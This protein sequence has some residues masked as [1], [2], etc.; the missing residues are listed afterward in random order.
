MKIS[1][2]TLILVVIGLALAAIATP[3]LA[4]PPPLYKLE[5]SSFS[6]EFFI[7][8][9]GCTVTTAELSTQHFV[10]GRPMAS[11]NVGT[12]T[13]SSP[14]PI[15]A[16]VSVGG[17]D[18]VIRNGAEVGFAV[19]DVRNPGNGTVVATYAILPPDQATAFFGS[20]QAGANAWLKEHGP[21]LTY[22]GYLYVFKGES[23]TDYVVVPFT[24][25]GDA[26]SGFNV[27]VSMP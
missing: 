4:S 12:I 2:K 25:Q 9:T 24:A 23:P 11:T 14:T 16:A 22:E 27:T 19:V 13:A 6:V 26:V 20:P 7:P 18:I 10:L 8:E 15:C 5:Q 21:S 3:V 1:R 17:L